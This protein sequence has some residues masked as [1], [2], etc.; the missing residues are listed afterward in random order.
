MVPRLPALPK[1]RTGNPWTDDGDVYAE[2]A[3]DDCDMGDG[4]PFH[5]MGPRATVQKGMAEHHR[6]Y[7]VEETHVVLLNQ[8]KH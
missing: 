3:N 2:C 5:M 6:F 8:R 1:L 4:H 7:H